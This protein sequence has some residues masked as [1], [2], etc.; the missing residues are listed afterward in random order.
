[1]RT[2]VVRYKV[3]PGMAAENERLIGEVFAQIAREKPQCLRYQSFK[4]A[5]GVSFMHVAS[6]QNAEA[7]PL[8]KLEAFK[9]F[10]AGIKERCEEPPVTTEM[11]VV[12][13]YDA[14]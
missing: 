13:A 5:D 7:S 2:V 9:T 11:Q 4:R 14:L 1:M 6:S 12:G 8:P 3:K 10:V